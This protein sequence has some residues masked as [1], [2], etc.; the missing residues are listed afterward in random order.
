[1]RTPLRHPVWSGCGRPSRTARTA[2]LV[3]L[4][5]L[6]IASGIRAEPL[7]P[8]LQDF[9]SALAVNTAISSDFA[10]SDMALNRES[11]IVTVPSW[12]GLVGAPDARRRGA[13]VEGF[14]S[15]GRFEL[16]TGSTMGFAAPTAGNITPSFNPQ[17][18]R[19][20]NL[21]S[22]IAEGPGAALRF[23][24][25]TV[26]SHETVLAAP[27]LGARERNAAGLGSALELA[28]GRLH[29]NGEVAGTQLHEST[30]G[31]ANTEGQTGSAGRV[32]ANAALL[33]SDVATVG[34]NAFHQSAGAG[35]AGGIAS[36]WAHSGAGTRVSSGPLTFGLMAERRHNNLE[37]DPSVLTLDERAIRPTLALSLARFRPDATDGF[38]AGRLVPSTV[39]ITYGTMRRTGT[40]EPFGTLGEGDA[41]DE[42]IRSSGLAFD[43]S[44]TNAMTTTLAF[45]VDRTD[46]L[47]PGK[48][49]A[50][51]RGRGL[52]LSHAISSGQQAVTVAFATRRS[53]TLDPGDPA[54]AQRYDFT[55]AFARRDGPLGDMVASFSVRQERTEAL[56]VRNVDVDTVWQAK[57]AFDMADLPSAANDGRLSMAVAVKGN[58]PD[59][60]DTGLRS[61][62]LVLGLAARMR[63]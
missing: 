15:D 4:P 34:V 6:L 1:M 2:F 25:G 45:A 23:A 30:L 20:A 3:L 40:P 47:Q 60:D 39:R 29:L 35:Y 62:E 57:A 12:V 49:E 9:S 59:E 7:F 13:L 33:E 37:R 56:A 38:S 8:E 26:E 54:D 48:E 16:A 32:G 11:G 51:S 52:T 36:D 17:T 19:T 43:W 61:V 58:D 55:A 46:S 41:V 44:W 63:F 28:D 10:L 42:Q 21:R 24:A 53:E 14:G 18:R 50:D 31:F 27:G 22:E 5:A